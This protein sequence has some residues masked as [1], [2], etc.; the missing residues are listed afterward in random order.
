MKNLVFVLF[1]ILAPS[2][3]FIGCIENCRA[4]SWGGSMTVELPCGHKLFDVTWKEDDIWYA[5]RPMR[6]GGSSETYTFV[7]DSY[8]GVLEGSVTFVEC[9]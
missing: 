8:F 5:V 6:E 7:E 1:L 9:R 3:S 2:L 4:K